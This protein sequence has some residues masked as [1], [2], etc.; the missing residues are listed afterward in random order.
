MSE[1]AVSLTNLSKMYRLY[2]RPADRV[3]DVLGLNR[4]LFWRRNYYDEFWAIRNLDLQISRGERIGIIGRNGAGKSTLLKLIC[5]NLAPTEGS[6]QVGGSIQALMELGTG[7]HPE[8]TGR[9]NIHASLAYQGLPSHRIREKEAEIVDFAELEGFIDHPLKTYSTGMYTRLAFSTATAIDP[10]ILIVDEVLGAGD[11]YFAG[12]C[13]E[14]MRRITVDSGATVLFVSHDLASVQKLCDRVVWLDR[15]GVRMDGEPLD[16]SKAYYKTV[17]QEEAQRLLARAGAKVKPAIAATSP[18]K[19]TDSQTSHELLIARIAADPASD[20]S[21]SAKKPPSS[22][23]GEGDQDGPSIVTW[24][25]PDPRIEGVRFLDGNG[26]AVAGIEEGNELVIEI[27]YFASAKVCDP[28]FAMTIYLADG[29]QLCHANTVLSGMALGA[30][31][32]RGK[33]CFEYRPF[34]GGDGHYVLSCSIFKFLDP[35][36]CVVQPPYYD[37]HN[38]AYRFRVWRE[39]GIHMNLGILR[40]PCT[41]THYPQPAEPDMAV[42]QA[43]QPDCLHHNTLPATC[44]TAH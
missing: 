25:K 40:L 15:G 1:L 2:R 31:Q 19:P 6:V 38:R 17:Q 26:Q 36:H 30:I 42:R 16:V 24:A 14:R 29:T 39:L 44:R 23:K 9:Q 8:F 43:F 3:L 28:V 41:T 11:A 32:G 5:G 7:F 13:F 10:D 18:A 4:W 22:S 27:S 20:T 21:M 35:S 12:K 34:L 37:Q 33:V